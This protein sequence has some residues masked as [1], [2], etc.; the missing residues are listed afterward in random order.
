MTFTGRTEV[1]EVLLNVGTN[2]VIGTGFCSFWDDLKYQSQLPNFVAFS[3]HNGYLEI[4]LAG[5]FVGVCVLALMLLATWFRIHK[6][7]GKTGDFVVLRFA[8]LIIALIANFSESYFAIMSPVGFLFLIGA[9]SVGQTTKS[10]V[11]AG[12]KTRANP[13]TSRVAFES[14][15]KRAFSPA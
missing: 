2:P 15:K 14:V 10:R 5:G 6:A 4:Y 12:V 13:R 9:L 11:W 1:W 3:A 8:I 7:L